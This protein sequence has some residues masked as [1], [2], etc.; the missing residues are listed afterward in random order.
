MRERL[1]EWVAEA[2]QPV[3]ADALEGESLSTVI[4]VDGEKLF[5]AHEATT[6]NP[7]WFTCVA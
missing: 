2:V 7:A 1:L 3:I 4:R 6:A 5:I